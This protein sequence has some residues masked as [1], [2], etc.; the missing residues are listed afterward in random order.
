MNR[1]VKLLL[2]FLSLT[3]SFTSS[4][5][6]SWDGDDDDFYNYYAFDTDGDGEDDMWVTTDADG[7]GTAI[8]YIN[9]EGIF[10]YIMVEHSDNDSDDDRKDDECGDD[11]SLDDKEYPEEE[12]DVINYDEID[13]YDYVDEKEQVYVISLEE[14]I[15][16]LS[17]LTTLIDVL[18]HNLDRDARIIFTDQERNY[19][20]SEDGNIYLNPNFNEDGLLHEAIHVIQDY[21]NMLDGVTHGADNEFQAY[22]TDNILRGAAGVGSQTE[23]MHGF[24]QDQWNEFGEIIDKNSGRNDDGILWYNQDMLDYLNNLPYE[25]ITKRFRDYWEENK[26]PEMYYKNHNPEYDWNWE[27]LLNS[28]GFRKKQ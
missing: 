17:N 18:L 16:S 2:V 10:E 19:Y 24:T 8:G 28:I 15:S 20:N 14:A 22:L 25:E 26:G 21:N 1:T 6:A 11:E 9:D 3:F 7:H 13:L 4:C 5:F 12:N 27:V 23:P